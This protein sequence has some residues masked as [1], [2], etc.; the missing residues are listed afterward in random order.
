MN[1]PGMF[2]EL[3][4][5]KSGEISGKFRTCPGNFQ[6][7]S[8]TFPVNLRGNVRELSGQNPGNVREMSGTKNYVKPYKNLYEPISKPCIQPIHKTCFLIT[9]TSYVKHIKTY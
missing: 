7:N 5:N 2:R 6:E 1:F 9:F 3:S 4:G 8:G